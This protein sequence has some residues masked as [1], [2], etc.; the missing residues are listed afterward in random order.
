MMITVI[1][2]ISIM[3]TV[4]IM[5]VTIKEITIIKTIGKGVMINIIITQKNRG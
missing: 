4:T 2:I 5:I 1:I 3:T